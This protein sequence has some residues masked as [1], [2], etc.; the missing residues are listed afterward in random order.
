MNENQKNKVVIDRLAENLLHYVTPNLRMLLQEYIT[1]F[2]R[3]LLCKE[4]ELDEEIY[5]AFPEFGKDLKIV[6]VSYEVRKNLSFAFLFSGKFE[7]LQPCEYTY[8]FQKKGCYN[9]IDKDLRELLENKAAI[10]SE[11]DCLDD[12]MH[13]YTLI[14]LSVPYRHRD[15]KFQHV[16]IGSGMGHR[17]PKILGG[18][19]FEVPLNVTFLPENGSFRFD[20]LYLSDPEGDYLR[21]NYKRKICWMQLNTVFRAGNP[22][23]GLRPRAVV[24]DP[25][26]ELPDKS[27]GVVP[28]E[29]ALKVDAGDIEIP[30]AVKIPEDAQEQN[31]CVVDAE[32]IEVSHSTWADRLLSS[33]EENLFRLEDLDE[34]IAE[35]TAKTPEERAKD[36]LSDFVVF[37]YEYNRLIGD[38]V[39]RALFPPEH[40]DLDKARYNL[41]L[42]AN[43][44]EH[45]L[46]FVDV[47][48]ENV[49]IEENEYEKFKEDEL[50]DN[51]ENVDKAFEE[52][53][54]VVIY[55][56]KEKPVLNTDEI[57]NSNAMENVKKAIKKHELLWDA[58]AEKATQ[59]DAPMLIVIANDTAYRRTFRFNPKIYDMVCGFHLWLKDLTVDDMCQLFWEE[60]EKSSFGKKLDDDFKMYVKEYV[61]T[62]Y[63]KSEIRGRLFIENH[64]SK[65]YTKYVLKEDK[66]D[67]IAGCIPSYKLPSVD[68]ILKELREMV[69]LE[70]VVKRLEMVYAMKDVL[71][72]ANEAY[73]M[74]FEGN[75]G[76]GKT[77]V[78][79]MMAEMLF[80]MGVITRPILKESRAGDFKSVWRG[81]TDQ[82]VKGLIR[83]AYGGVLFIDE[84]YMLAEDDFQEGLAILLM[85][86]ADRD[87]PERPVVILAG[88]EDRMRDLLKANE[89]LDSR[90][91]CHV[92]FRDYTRQ[93]LK[94]ILE[95]KLH[96]LGFTVQDGEEAEKLLDDLILEKMSSEFFGNARDME[97]LCFELIGKWGEKKAE[98][99]TEKYEQSIR[100]EHMKAL[101]PETDTES[102]KKILEDQPQLKEELERFKIGV[103]YKKALQR[104]TDNVNIPAVNL[105]MIFAGS[106][107]TGK[108]TVAGMLAD[109]LCE[110]H[111]LPTNKCISVEAKDLLGY[112][113]NMTPAQHAGDYIN[114]AKGGILFI[115][116]AYSLAKER[117]GEEII[118]VLLTAM[119]KYKENTI[120]VFAGYPR[121]MKNFLMMNPGLESRIGYTFRFQSYEADVLTKMFINKMNGIGLSFADEKA[122]EKKLEDI[123][124]FFRV[125][126]DFGNG[127][128][129]ENLLN[130]TMNEHGKR[131]AE[132]HPGD[133]T[134]PPLYDCVA[135]ELKTYTADDVPSI[136]KIL[137]SNYG[138]DRKVDEEK[139]NKEQQKK[140]ERTAIHELGH[141][142]VAMAADS[143][144]IRDGFPV[145]EKITVKPDYYASGYVRFDDTSMEGTEQQYKAKLASFLGGRNAE[146]LYFGSHTHGCSQDYETAKMLAKQMV[147]AFAMGEMGITTKAELLQEADKRATQLLE[148]NKEFIDAMKP[149][150]MEYE[151]LEGA[152]IEGAYRAYIDFEKKD[153][154]Q[155]LEDLRKE[156]EKK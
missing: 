28:G 15:L 69:G 65:M 5:I 47:L 105:H 138:I 152:D 50:W 137:K 25:Y 78:A 16:E 27:L 66:D 40:K 89:G 98:E 125:R 30:E 150:L 104:N 17:T 57:G 14:K 87:N 151:E 43:D 31:V 146:K 122:A 156:Y 11:D 9:Y 142:T 93:E 107:G 68:R 36:I 55:D 118:H 86:M 75:P 56:C 24:V 129:V 139:Q 18:R 102:L 58:I 141:A 123:M 32:D 116:E 96:E 83:E 127:R 20:T 39:E 94:E 13:P 148:E 101:L 103:A 117:G 155:F 49:F 147:K 131:L 106:P 54:L 12:N 111:V 120:F 71:L 73:H 72:N 70:D 88:Y 134:H 82:K 144:R 44:M 10:I 45:A 115:D 153:F 41:L 46:K 126:E 97:K 74:S 80:H 37:Q 48:R 23:N 100:A 133:E 3:D 51:F 77:M 1:K 128:F 92:K 29:E 59:Q 130:E 99:G 90:I 113:R 4:K 143:T 154:E 81:G 91:K 42:K 136:E 34:D 121:D 109:Y 67:S 8:K 62:V 85:E 124:R 76:T 63:P 19:D 22:E 95:R 110:I 52:K 145:V 79:K 53:K 6:P 132:K 33:L 21:D 2:R 114:R 26:G 64:L 135:E 140:K 35:N 60:L 61:Q 112:A 149:L 7:Q 119:E 84:A 38:S 108:T